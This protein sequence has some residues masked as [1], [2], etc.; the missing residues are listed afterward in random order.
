[1]TLTFDLSFKTVLQVTLAV[2]ACT[3]N[4][5]SHFVLDLQASLAH[6]DGTVM[7]CS[8]D[9]DFPSDSS[10]RS[11]LTVLGVLNTSP[12]VKFTCPFRSY[13]TFFV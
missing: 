2:V 13:C 8:C 6:I 11:S 4:F 1:V 10:G 5:L 12:S 7:C 9:R 3:A